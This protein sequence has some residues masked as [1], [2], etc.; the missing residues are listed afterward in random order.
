MR[1]G[2]TVIYCKMTG[3]AG[4]CRGNSRC[5]SGRLLLWCQH[6]KAVRY[7]SRPLYSTF[8]CNTA[9]HRMNVRLLWIGTGS[10]RLEAERGVTRSTSSLNTFLLMTTTINI[11]QPRFQVLSSCTSTQLN[12]F[13]I[14]QRLPSGTDKRL[15]DKHC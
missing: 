6:Y 7:N 9:M 4:K 5:Y 11:L 14:S 3:K 13:Y 8:C 10:D 15:S 1:E 2:L 12:Y